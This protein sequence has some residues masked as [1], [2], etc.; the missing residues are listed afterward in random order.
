MSGDAV[1]YAHLVDG[2]R[3]LNVPAGKPV[4]AHASLSSLGQVRG[5]AA[6]VVGALLAVFPAVLMPTFTYKTML[7]PEDGPPN[8]GIAYGTGFD[9]NRMAEFYHPEMPADPLIGAVAETLRRHR[10]AQRSRHPILSFAGV[11]VSQALEAQTLREPLA[12]IRVLIEQAGWVLLL[13]VDHTVNTSIHY[14]ERLAGRRQFVRWALTPSGVVECPGFPGCSLG[15]QAIAP[16]VEAITRR[17]TIGQATVQALPLHGLV[18]QVQA[19]IRRDPLALLCE[20]E[21]CPRC[22]AVR[23]AVAEAA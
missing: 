19:L 17:V 10:Q 1:R 7:T 4:I 21:D 5:G 15:F 9:Q 22:Q 18:A 20:R 16:H 2:L 8:N 6:T 11:G 13:G 12:P 3:A 14:G 23:Q